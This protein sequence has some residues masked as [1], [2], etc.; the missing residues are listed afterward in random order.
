MVCLPLGS[1][2]VFGLG[3]DRATTADVLAWVYSLGLSAACISAFLPL[4]S[5]RTWS[6]RHRVQSSVLLFLVMSYCTHLTW[7]L[8]W[9]LLHDSIAAA[10]NSAWAYPWWAYIDGGDSRYATAPVELLAGL[11]S[12]DT[13]SFTATF[14]K[15]GLANA[16]WFTMPW[17]V[18]W[19]GFNLISDGQ[20]AS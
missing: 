15:F 8:G 9:L 12:V 16:P 1:L 3:T 14:I 4:P 19:W 18:L 6:R 5:L 17:L 20:R 10:R 11:P 2:A 7:E 13:T